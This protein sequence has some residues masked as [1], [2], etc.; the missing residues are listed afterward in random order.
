MNIKYTNGEDQDFINLC[1][2]LDDNLNEIVGGEKQRAEYNQYNMLNHIHDVFI[3]Y[4]DELP[5]GC[6]SFKY[7]DDG[8]AEVKRVFVRKDYR[9]RGLS[10]L[11][12][13]QVEKKARE[14]GYRSLILETGKPMTE[15][16]GLYTKIGY[17]V[18]ENYGQYKNM[19][20]SVCMSK[21]IVD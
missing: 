6:A 17:N 15:A 20:L 10:K 3:A 1:S 21:N 14:Q 8:I 5:V 2:M 4:E 13:E 11:L 19:P 18:I 7:Y 16:I 9:G 12:M